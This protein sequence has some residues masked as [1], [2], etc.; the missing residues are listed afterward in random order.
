MLY[1]NELNELYNRNPQRGIIK[2]TV[3]KAG[4][5][6]SHIPLWELLLNK[7]FK[8]SSEKE[9]LFEA[10]DMRTGY[11]CLF[12]LPP[13]IQMIL[14]NVFY[15]EELQIEKDLRAS[16][17]FN[18]GYSLQSDIWSPQEVVVLQMQ[19]LSHVVANPYQQ[20]LQRDFS[21]EMVNRISFMYKLPTSLQT[22]DV[23]VPI[24]DR[25]ESLLSHYQV[26]E[27][28][29]ALIASEGNRISAANLIANRLGYSERG[30][31]EVIGMTEKWLIDNYAT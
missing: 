2:R 14:A 15:R 5:L 30:K 21:E 3:A 4:G 25:I 18:S 29:F 19:I 20:I 28:E 16:S 6:A 22:F 26:Q 8:I 9:D 13:Y 17:S 23:S 1:I 31:R 11:S 12:I 27:P 10:L 24:R 7:T